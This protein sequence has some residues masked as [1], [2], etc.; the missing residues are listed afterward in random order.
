M[1]AQS[2]PKAPDIPSTVAPGAAPK[3]LRA[4]SR[5]GHWPA[6]SGRKLLA[7]YKA[8][9]VRF[10]YIVLKNS[11]FSRGSFFAQRSVTPMTRAKVLLTSL[12]ELCTE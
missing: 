8:I 6:A 12:T 7:R 9:K 5:F 1:R 11:K 4:T 3:L 10:Q 2:H